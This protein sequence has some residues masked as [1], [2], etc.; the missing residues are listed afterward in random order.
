MLCDRS[1]WVWLRRVRTFSLMPF[2]LGPR[3]A[4]RGLPA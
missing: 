3:A 1:I 2:G 4:S